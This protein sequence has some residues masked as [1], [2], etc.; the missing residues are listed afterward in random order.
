MEVTPSGLA[1]LILQLSSKR[2][3]KTV[4]QHGEEIHHFIF[5]VT[6]K[7]FLCGYALHFSGAVFRGK[8]VATKRLTDSDNLGAVFGVRQG[9]L[10]ASQRDLHTRSHCARINQTSKTAF[11]PI[12]HP[13]AQ[14]ASS[15]SGRWGRGH[16]ASISP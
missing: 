16:E 15:L 9:Q 6:Q 12:T 8:Q 7:N 13:S 10:F 11:G 2:A 5:F 14:F 1:K 3:G 4:G